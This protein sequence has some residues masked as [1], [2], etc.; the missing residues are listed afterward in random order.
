LINQLRTD[1]QLTAQ[2]SA[3]AALNDLEILFR[4]LTL[5][6]VMDRVTKIKTENSI[7]NVKI[8]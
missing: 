1:T 7:L 4:Y 6:G 8:F 5:F 2:K 3:V